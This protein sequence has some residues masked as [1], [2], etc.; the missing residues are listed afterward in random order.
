MKQ[1]VSRKN[2]HTE[3]VKQLTEKVS[4][5]YKIF[6]YSMLEKDKTEIFE[7]CDKIKFYSC[8]SEYFEWNEEISKKAV[9][10]LKDIR[11]PLEELWMYYIGHEYISVS[12]WED[13]D[14][15]LA[16]YS[17]RLCTDITS[18]GITE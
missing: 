8:V 7:S 11:H 15:M 6:Y 16:C 4:D 9:K 18:D 12:S 10:K 14:E 2:E 3:D 13:I 17:D 1:R 5:E